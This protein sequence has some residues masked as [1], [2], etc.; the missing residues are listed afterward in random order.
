MTRVLLALALVGIA[1][2][3]A[4]VIEKRRPAP[5]TQPRWAVPSQVDRDDFDGADKPWLVVVFTSATCDTC[6]GVWA[7]VRPLENDEVAVHEVEAVLREDLHQRYAIDAVP[8]LLV[9]DRE[10]V[11]RGS[12]VGP[13][14]AEEI[15]SAVSD[16]RDNAPGA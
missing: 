11:V 7:R 13:A 5:P 3:V 12:L 15:W 4:L 2:V 14:S 1:I 8:L 9:V 10:G 16:V 6:A